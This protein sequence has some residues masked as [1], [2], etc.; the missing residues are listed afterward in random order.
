[1]TS[2]ETELVNSPAELVTNSAQIIEFMLQVVPAAEPEPWLRKQQLLRDGRPTVAGVLLFAEEPQAAVP[3]HCGIKIYRYKTDERSRES[4]AFD[5][6]TVEGSLYPQIKDA[7]DQTVR[8]VEQIKKLGQDGLESIS[9]PMEA[10]HEIITNAV[11]HRDYSVADDVHIR[12]FDNRIEV[13]SPGRLPGHVTPRNIL[14]ERFARNGTIV[15]ILNKYPQ[16][17]NKDVGEGLNTAFDAMHK[18]GLKSP[19]IEERENSVLVT[20]RHEPLASPEEAIMEYLSEHPQI[21][22]SE[23]RK[24]CHIH[25]D[26]AVKVIFQRMVEKGLIEKVPG[27][28]TAGTA[29]RSKRTT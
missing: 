2:F 29:Y 5:P 3:K 6:I 16:A 8:V 17:P 27:T 10:L 23:A 4:L 28:R 12:V 15:R 7:V 24:L 9:Y 19:I 1:V 21:R 26:Y 14:D 25:A 22:N 11:L 20:I 18:L 13:E